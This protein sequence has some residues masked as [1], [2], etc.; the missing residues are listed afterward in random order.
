MIHQIQAF[1]IASLVFRE[2]LIDLLREKRSAVGK[3]FQLN[4]FGH[5]IETTTQFCIVTKADI[6]L[7]Q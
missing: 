2:R 3:K 1:L 6:R 5:F 7:Q 4:I